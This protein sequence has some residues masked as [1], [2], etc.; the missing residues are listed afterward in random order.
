MRYDLNFFLRKSQFA[1]MAALGVL[2]LV[3]VLESFFAPE[4]MV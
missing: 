3:L 4:Q 1:L 2:P